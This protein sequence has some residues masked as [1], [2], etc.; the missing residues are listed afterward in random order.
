MEFLVAAQVVVLV[1]MVGY[2][3][4]IRARR[5]ALERTPHTGSGRTTAHSAR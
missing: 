4:W 1:S 3:L 2:A 5:N